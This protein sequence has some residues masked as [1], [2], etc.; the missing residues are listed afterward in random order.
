MA[1]K[2]TLQDIR[3]F[4][5]AYEEES[6]TAAAVRENCTQSGVSHHIRQLESLF[7]IK[8]FNRDRAKVTSTPA[9]DDFYRHCVKLL[10]KV[11]VASE[12]VSRFAEGYQTCFNVGVIPALAHRVIAPALVRFTEENPNVKVGIIENFSTSLTTMVS[13]GAVDF[14]FGTAFGR[15]SGVRLRPLLS[16]PECLIASGEGAASVTLKELRESGPHKIVW[17]EGMQ[18]RRNA[19]EGWLADKGIEV[20]ATM[21]VGSSLVTLD[22]VSRS[23]WKTV[24]P[25]IILDPETDLENLTAIP[26]L[27]PDIR[28]DLTVVERISSELPQEAEEFIR[29]V[30]EEAK[31]V[32]LAWEDIFRKRGLQGPSSL[33]WVG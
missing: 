23:T 32:N 12:A 22:M 3:L 18:S 25:A 4:I 1:F 8:L 21:E 14:A 7:G 10:R 2:G 15:E 30:V 28:L 33:K 11:D 6:F 20:A 9:G 24:S 16:S 29:L 31:R 5:A 19:I 17:A 13:S 26:L 27:K